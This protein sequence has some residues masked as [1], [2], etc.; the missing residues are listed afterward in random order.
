MICGVQSLGGR[1]PWRGFA[2]KQ[3]TPG[4]GDAYLAQVRESQLTRAWPTSLGPLRTV[5]SLGSLTQ[6][7]PSADLAGAHSHGWGWLPAP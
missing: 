6:L 7:F 2:V 4:T 1:D 3:K 5:V